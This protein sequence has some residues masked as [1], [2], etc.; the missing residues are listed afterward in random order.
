VYETLNAANS[1]AVL[2]WKPNWH[3]EWTRFVEHQR[4]AVF[5]DHLRC[6]RDLGQKVGF[7]LYT[8]RINHS[9][10]STIK[11]STTP[12]APGCLRP[13]QIHEMFRIWCEQMQWSPAVRRRA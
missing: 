8:H 11:Q 5:I 4:Q 1:V 13:H 10:V 2:G 12:I 9:I 6:A 3:G 7:V